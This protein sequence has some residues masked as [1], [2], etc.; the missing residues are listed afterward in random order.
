MISKLQKM[1]YDFTIAKFYKKKTHI[2]NPIL[3]LYQYNFSTTLLN[4]IDI[5]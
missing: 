3:L 4:M 2:K 5:P 1:H